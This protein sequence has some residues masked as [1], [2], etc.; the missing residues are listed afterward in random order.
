MV[1]E[2]YLLDANSFIT[3]Y[4]NYYPFDFAPAYWRQLEP[5]LKQENVS[6][7]DVVKDEIIRGGDKLTEWVM[8]I[9]DLN[10]LDRRDPKIIASYSKVL[11][12]IQ[13]SPLYNDRALRVWSDAS[14]A[15]PWLIAA[16]S[17]YD[18]VIVTVESA[19]GTINPQN[20]SGKPK[21][22]DIA[23]EMGVKCENLFY[24][25]RNTGIKFD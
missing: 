1:N 18:Y 7:M 5:L 9:E 15:D 22:P 14:V 25:M 21:I 19:A 6:V 4:Q 2:K 23:R 11:K 3:P 10:V 20:P 8:A 12:F 24:F 16:A 17:A 13:D